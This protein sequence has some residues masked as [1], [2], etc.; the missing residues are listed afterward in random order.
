M[1]P[2]SS[3]GS[4]CHPESGSRFPCCLPGSSCLL[5][6]Q[7]C[8]PSPWGWAVTFPVVPQASTEGPSWASAVAQ[9]P[10]GAGFSPGWERRPVARRGP[11]PVR[12]CDRAALRPPRGAGHAGTCSP[13]VAGSSLPLGGRGKRASAPPIGCWPPGLPACGGSG[14]GPAGVAVERRRL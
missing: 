14:V 3:S 13:T 5:S 10:G 12:G 1:Q 8:S 2:P 7:P 6:P 9:G 11:A 4:Q